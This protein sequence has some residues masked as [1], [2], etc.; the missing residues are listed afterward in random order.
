MHRLQE[1]VR[2]HR[3][4]TGPR[5]VV[6]LLSMSPNTE[7]A[8]RR[9]LLAAELL[10]GPPSEVPALEELKAAVLAHQPEKPRPPQQRSSIE[11]WRASIEELMVEHRMRP[12]AIF[13][14][15]QEKHG[16]SFEGTYP[17]VKRLCRS[18]RRERGVSPE[19]V[20]IVVETPPGQ[21]AQVDF[22]YVGRLLDP[23]T[24]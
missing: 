24:S 19:D 1:L 2:L 12:K 22:G 15:L 4:G 3:E 16:D 9:A 21:V 5:E 23:A 10:E 7:R 20:A 11:S 8:Y 14:R 17:Q 6:R 18:I 13:H